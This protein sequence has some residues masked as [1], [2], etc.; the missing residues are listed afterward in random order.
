MKSQKARTKPLALDASEHEHQVAFI[1]WIRY[2][3]PGV[4][5]YA[6][7]NGGHR[8]V[9]VAAKLKNEGVLAGIPDLFI[10][11]GKPGM[12]IEL[13]KPGGR[14]SEKQKTILNGLHEAGYRVA[15]CYGWEDAKLAVEF[16]LKDHYKNGK[17]TNVK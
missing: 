5:A 11:D 8:D 2:A 10:A 6:I 17:V 3:Y 16:Y 1:E 12:Y 15:V 9:R 14:V 7:P 4:I 13:K